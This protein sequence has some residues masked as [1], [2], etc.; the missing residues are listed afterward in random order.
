[1]MNLQKLRMMIVT[2][3]EL[4]YWKRVSNLVDIIDKIDKKDEIYR[5]MWISKLKDLMLTKL[6]KIPTDDNPIK[7]LKH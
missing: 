5:E 3:N 2:K 1:M 6:P 4:I 7:P